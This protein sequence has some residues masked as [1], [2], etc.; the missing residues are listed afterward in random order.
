M[1][2][3]KK[4][5][6][7]VYSVLKSDLL[8]DT[9]FEFTDDSRKWVDKVFCSFFFLFIYSECVDPLVALHVLSFY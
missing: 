7:D 6:L 9:A 8:E 2:D 1:A 5:F 4:K 3:L